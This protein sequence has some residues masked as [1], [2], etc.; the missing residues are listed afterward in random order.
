MAIKTKTV[1][2]E[3]HQG[4]VTSLGAGFIV[5]G[6]VSIPGAVEGVDY[7]INEKAGVIKPTKLR[8]TITA[9]YQHDDLEERHAT[10]RDKRK[11][12][13]AALLELAKTNAS[14]KLVCEYLGIL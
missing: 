4:E 3:V 8:G 7:A 13:K 11:A 1:T 12:A 5:P 6:S 14:V 2:I 9:T 10:E